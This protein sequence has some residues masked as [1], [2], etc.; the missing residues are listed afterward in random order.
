M[1]CILPLSIVG[2]GCESEG[3]GNKNIS[4]AADAAAR[5]MLDVAKRNW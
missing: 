1:R 3:D 4:C 2:V 5:T